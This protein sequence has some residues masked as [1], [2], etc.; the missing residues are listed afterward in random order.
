[1]KQFIPPFRAQ[2][3]FG[4]PHVKWARALSTK[5]HRPLPSVT[6]PYF[7]VA[8]LGIVILVSTLLLLMP[9]SNTSGGFTPPLSAIFAATSAATL[10]GLDTQEA[11]GFWTKPGELILIAVMG[12]AG[13]GSMT[14]AC[15][16]ISRMGHVSNLTTLTAGSAL[17]ANQ[18]QL[19][20]QIF[21]RI[22]TFALVVQVIGFVALLVRLSFEF[23]PLDASWYA[24]YTTVSGFNNGGFISLTNSNELVPL[25][26]DLPLLGLITALILT[27]ALGWWTLSD[28][29]HSRRWRKLQLNSKLVLIATAALVVIGAAGYLL[30][31]FTNGDTIAYLPIEQKIMVSIFEAT[32]S[33]T[34][35]LTSVG[36]EDARQG[37]QILFTALMF[38]GGAAGSVAGGIK[39]GTLAIIIMAIFTTIR[40]KTKLSPL[41]REIP[42]T[43]V[44]KALS[45]VLTAIAFT[46]CTTILLSITEA[47]SELEFSD[48]IFEN[49]SAISTAGL[50]TG[51][52]ADFSNLG[53]I[54]LMVS[55]VIGRLGLLILV[56]RLTTYR[57][58]YLYRSVTERVTIG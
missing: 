58:P 39:V 54:I 56:M 38:I 14:F 16:F 36:F 46:I 25:L 17:P 33:R 7:P 44:T 6:S 43:L 51:N 31:E 32:S 42:D 13:I 3:R 57:R 11:I 19:F 45:I 20:R 8:L 41:E 9:F 24:L 1:M 35:G 30:T 15:F 49:V 4:I 22:V 23:E 50:S 21:L 2:R 48:I 27:G 5:I 53:Q 55:M 10:T 40:R 18:T 29:W 26:S 37:T 34:A 12:I 28:V 52:T 47:S